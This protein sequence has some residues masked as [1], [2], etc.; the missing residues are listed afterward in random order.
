MLV[1]CNELA[2]NRSTAEEFKL[3]QTEDGLEEFKR[4]L[5]Q[6]QLFASYVNNFI[7]TF[8]DL[9][10]TLYYCYILLLLYS[11]IIIFYY[12]HILLLLYSIKAHGLSSHIYAS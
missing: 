9:A 6:W 5:N 7:Y 8:D 1:C 3:L 11:I 4:K 2:E 12:Y 10:C